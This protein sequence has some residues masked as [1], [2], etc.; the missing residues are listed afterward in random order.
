[1]YLTVIRHY[2]SKPSLFSRNVKNKLVILSCDELQCIWNICKKKNVQC[3]IESSFKVNEPD[4]ND[5][6]FLFFFIKNK[7]LWN[8][9]FKKSNQM[10]EWRQVDNSTQRRYAVPENF[11]IMNQIALLI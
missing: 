1:M 6:P 11:N 4:F 5:S 7:K 2:P 3:L 8:F 9:I 10:T